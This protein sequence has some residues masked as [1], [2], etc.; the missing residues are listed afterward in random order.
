MLGLLSR[1]NEELKLAARYGSGSLCSPA[2]LLIGRRGLTPGVRLIQFMIDPERFDLIKRKHGAYGSWAVWVPSSGRP[3][4]N[5]ANLDV[6]DERLNT[7]LLETLNPGVVMVGLNLG[8]GAGTDAPFRNFHSCNP[9][10]HDFKIRR[11]FSG[12]TFWGAYMTDIIKDRVEPA[13]GKLVGWLKQN[14]H[15][16]ADNVRRL[17]AEL[18]D[19]G[20]SRP[21]ILAFGR[22]AYDLLAKNLSASDYACLV[23]LRHYSDRISEDDYREEVHRQLRS[24]G[25]A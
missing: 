7:A 18:S 15:V 5:V 14:P 4:S 1:S 25:T 21:V 9:K 16:I 17:R 10:A 24:I 19:L 13:S 20:H 3:K 2:A 12:T 8:H 23:Q 11:A 6:L 22:A